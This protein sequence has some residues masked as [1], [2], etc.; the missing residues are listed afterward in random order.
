MLVLSF[1]SVP[2]S[3]PP[4]F[5]PLP[6]PLPLSLQTEKSGMEEVCQG[7]DEMV[8]MKEQEIAAKQRAL[9]EAEQQV[10][11][12]AEEC[13]ALKGKLE[14]GTEQ[15]LS[16]QADVQTLQVTCT[17]VYIPSCLLLM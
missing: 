4:S 1:I 8:A 17:V 6:S 13:A 3:L 10:G 15:I 5:P 12:L 9:S 14:G 11:S 7:K 16:L 2:P